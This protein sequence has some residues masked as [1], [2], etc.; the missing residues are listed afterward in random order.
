LQLRKTRI[1]TCGLGAALTAALCLAGC[2][3]GAEHHSAPPP[4]LP[5]LLAA[6]LAARSDQVAAA[7]DAGDSCLALDE[8]HRLQDDTIKSINE[9]RIPGAFQEHL[10][11]AVSDL[12]GRIQC[13]PPAEKHGKGK[14]KGK[15]KHGEND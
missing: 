3:S 4:K 12:V 8:A 13:A 11:S 6:Q 5:P 10:A 9:G 15:H 7:L 1:R 14:G 2:G